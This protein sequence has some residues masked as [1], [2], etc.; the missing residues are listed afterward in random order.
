MAQPTKI[1]EAPAPAQEVDKVAL[2]NQLTARIDAEASRNQ[3]TPDIVKQRDAL[4]KEIAAS[5]AGGTS[6]QPQ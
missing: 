5:D 6:G 3:I 1:K 4:L 2:L